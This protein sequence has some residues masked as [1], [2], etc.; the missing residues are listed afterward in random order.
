MDANSINSITGEQE[1]VHVHGVH[2][3]DGLAGT[4]P[5]SGSN[6]AENT[7]Y[8]FGSSLY[9]RAALAVAALGLMA[10]T[11]YG[12]LIAGFGTEYKGDNPDG[13]HNWETTVTNL[14]DVASSDYAILELDIQGALVQGS[15]ISTDKGW[16]LLT[17]VNQQP[18]PQDNKFTVGTSDPDEYLYP[19]IY[20]YPDF[21]IMKINY[22]TPADFDH[23]GEGTITAYSQYAG[24]IDLQGQTVI[25]EPAVLGLLTVFGSG[26]L[27]SRRIFGGDSN[28][29]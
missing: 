2:S 20:G 27:L 4:A 12:A 3:M 10:A 9:S 21:S 18:N 1:A 25:P 16:D 29:I 22:T 14:S 24:Q 28:G 13:T 7:H 26:I 19:I 6:R 8:G 5:D 11:S 15:G 23:L 17:Y